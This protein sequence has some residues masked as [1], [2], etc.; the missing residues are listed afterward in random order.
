MLGENKTPMTEYFNDLN[1]MTDEE[2]IAIENG[3][4]PYFF[5]ARSTTTPQDVIIEAKAILH[6]RNSLLTSKKKRWYEMP[7]GILAL[8]IA[9][10]LLAWLVLHFFGIA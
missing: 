1:Q 4:L 2:L 8:G 3:K 6:K 9:A 10:S 7:L 5:S